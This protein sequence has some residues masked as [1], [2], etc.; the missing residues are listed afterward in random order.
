MASDR[1]ANAPP[2]GVIVGAD[3]PLPPD[4]RASIVS[5]MVE[6]LIADLLCGEKS[7]VT[8][9]ARPQRPRRID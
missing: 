6:A 5:L 4:L 7:S 9:A 3:A 1:I 8:Q 2:R